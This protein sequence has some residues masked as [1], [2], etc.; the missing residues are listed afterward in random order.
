MSYNNGVHMRIGLVVCFLFLISNCSAVHAAERTIGVF[1][2]LADNKSQGIVPVP[3]AIGNGDDPEKNLYWGSSEGLKGFFDDSKKWKLVSKNDH[4]IKR[5]ILRERTYNLKSGKITLLARAYRGSAI[6]NCMNDYESAV[7]NGSF[8]LAVYIGHNGLMDFRLP[9]PTKP[10]RQAKHPDCIVLCCK[11]ESYFKSRIT[12]AGGRP[13]L[14][15]TQLMYPG[16]FLVDA[17]VDTWQKRTNLNEIRAS[18]GASYARNQK[19][20]RRA[21]TG[22]FA[23]L[24]R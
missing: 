22:V 11:S 17:V 4:P 10:L 9:K 14:L 12:A 15:T 16:S 19:I 20:S 1:V 7:S 24:K 21:G 18:A 3:V 13:I 23:D 2:A 8:D 5:D 6:K